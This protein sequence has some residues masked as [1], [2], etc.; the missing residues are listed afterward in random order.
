MKLLDTAVLV[1]IDRGGVDERVDRLDDEG[2]H[3][4]NI[5]TVT[6]LHLGVEKQYEDDDAYQSAVS[7]L[8]RFLSRFDVRPIDRA[9]AVTAARI[10]AD[11][12]DRGVPLH[13]LHDVY[14]AATAM[15]EQ[16]AVLTPNVSH[17]DRIE[18]VTVVDWAAY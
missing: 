12:E 17:F 5:V 18:G 3:C 8:E 13:D 9:T 11:L 2:R 16:L 15:T 6:E 1:D 7:D 10:I 14:I 4:V